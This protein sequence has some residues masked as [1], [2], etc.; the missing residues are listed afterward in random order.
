MWPGTEDPLWWKSPFFSQKNPSLP[1]VFGLG[2]WQAGLSK[3][4]PASLPILLLVYQIGECSDPRLRF[5]FRFWFILILPNI[6]LGQFDT[7]DVSI[8]LRCCQKPW[9]G[10]LDRNE[11]GDALSCIWNDLAPYVERCVQVSVTIV[12][13]ATGSLWIANFLSVDFSSCNRHLAENPRFLAQFR[14]DI[15]S[16]LTRRDLALISFHPYK[17][18]RRRFD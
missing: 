10:K 14:L 5:V 16:C 11:R 2:F 7:S 6:L 13:Y 15:T 18:P 4:F 8:G 12:S 17:T 9:R 1:L 3:G